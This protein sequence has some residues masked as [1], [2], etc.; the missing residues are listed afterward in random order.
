VPNF[1][2]GIGLPQLFGRAGI[3]V[4]RLV[5]GW[6]TLVLM[7]VPDDGLSIGKLT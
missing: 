1:A 2:E 5:A 6:L 3:Q 4:H 7:N